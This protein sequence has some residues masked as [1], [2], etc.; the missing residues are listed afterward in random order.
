M[1]ITTK[2]KLISKTI[3]ILMNPQW[4]LLCIQKE[5]LH[6]KKIIMSFQIC[7]ED[8]QR[9]SRRPQIFIFYESFFPRHR[10]CLISTHSYHEL[11]TYFKAKVNTNQIHAMNIELEALVNNGTWEVVSFPTRKKTISRWVYKLQ[12]KSDFLRRATLR[13]MKLIMKRFLFLYPIS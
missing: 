2:K 4:I 11:T 7:P 1:S 8:P 6:L 5:I 9:P 12:T 3:K 13:N 10:T